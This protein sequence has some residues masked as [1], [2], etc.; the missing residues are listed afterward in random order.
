MTTTTLTTAEVTVE[1]GPGLLAGIGEGP[2]LVAH[3]ARL[4]TPPRTRLATLLADLERV[5]LRGRGGAGFPFARKLATTAHAR[6]RAT[7]VVNA[8]EGEPPSSKDAALALTAPHLVLDGAVVAADALGARQVHLVVPDVDRPVR[9]ALAAAV[10][11][12]AG[13]RVRW[14]VHRADDVFVAGQAAAVV[15]LMEG[16]P[17]RPV[18]TWQPAAVRGYRGRPTLLSNAETYAQLGLLVLGGADAYVNRG[19]VDEPGTALLTVHDGGGRR[20]VE[21]ELGTPWHDVLA[22]DDLDRPALLGGYHGMWA[23]PGELRGLTVSRSGLAAAGLTLGAGVV[24]VPDTCP[25]GF[26]ST[27]ASYL[28]TQSARRCGPCL[29]GLPALAAALERVV[30]GVAGRAETERLCT[31]VER[32][33]ACAHPD[34]TARMVRSAFARFPDEVDRH[35]RGGCTYVP[36]IGG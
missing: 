13:D 23:A 36:G 29:N 32:R 20:V 10:A 31:V 6:G 33:G 2:S 7:V 1:R 26:A 28:A 11:E 21:V 18:T 27:V 8:S 4:G 24:L 30:S 16:R 15:E 22:P 5:D 3:R 14:V 35:A 25:L 12:R 34:G 19:S 9:D 17:N